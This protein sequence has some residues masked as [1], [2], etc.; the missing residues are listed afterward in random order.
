MSTLKH[1]HP[2]HAEVHHEAG[3]LRRPLDRHDQPGQ[4]GTHSAPND[5]H[6]RDIRRDPVVEPRTET[7]P[8]GTPGA[9]AS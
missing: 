7:A 4:G 8:L 9:D 3:E 1:D 2:A 5:G 6:E